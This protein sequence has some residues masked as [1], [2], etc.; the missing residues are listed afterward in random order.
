MR[1][2]KAFDEAG[3]LLDAGAMAQTPSSVIVDA[4]KKELFLS[5][6]SSEVIEME[7]LPFLEDD[8]ISLAKL[9][10]TCRY[11]R[12]T[13]FGFVRSLELSTHK[14][15]SATLDRM[16]NLTSLTLNFPQRDELPIEE[17]NAVLASLAKLSKLRILDLSRSTVGITDPVIKALPNLEELYLALEPKPIR[18]NTSSYSVEALSGLKKLRVLCNVLVVSKEHRNALATLTGLE[19][20]SFECLSGVGFFVFAAMTQLK[21]LDLFNC[22]IAKGLIFP[23]SIIKLRLSN[24]G[25]HPTPADAPNLSELINLEELD[26][27]DFANAYTD[28]D[29]LALPKLRLVRG[30]LGD[31]DWTIIK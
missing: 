28:Y 7:L 9:A 5:A 21:E 31:P 14:D 29:L 19:K 27:A 23:P 15:V 4:L 18:Y 10:Q 11:F 22:Y 17:T 1:S 24:E 30:L 12:D 8:A 2:A 20:L 3:E 25:F 16:P 26:L 13:V 6:V